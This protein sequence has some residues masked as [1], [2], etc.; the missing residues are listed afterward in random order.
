MRG[1]FFD[2]GPPCC[3]TA[4][5]GQV[6]NAYPKNA[7]NSRLFI[8]SAS[9]S[10]HR[11]N[12]KAE[13]FGSLEIDGQE[14]FCR[15]LDRQV[16]RLHRSQDPVYVSRKS[17]VH[18]C[19]IHPDGD[20]WSACLLLSESFLEENLHVSVRLL[21]CGLFWIVVPF[22][23]ISIAMKIKSVVCPLQ[24]RWGASSLGSDLRVRPPSSIHFFVDWAA[25]SM[26]SLEAEKSKGD[27]ASGQ[28]GGTRC[29]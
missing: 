2:I 7:T 11:R 24:W 26:S 28:S 9:T 1:N 6:A 25:R 27:T 12:R 10:N 8:Q 3:A 4:A 18:V 19:Q 14:K 21:G 23:P 5:L 29:T 22:C 17:P 15:A 20:H 13:I 16:S